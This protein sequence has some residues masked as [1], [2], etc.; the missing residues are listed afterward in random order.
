MNR[1]VKDDIIGKTIVVKGG[2]HKGHRG[3]VT[4]ADDKNVIVELNTRNKKIPI[5]RDLVE[6]LKPDD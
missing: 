6:V 3:R 1:R 2:E 4:Q 5:D